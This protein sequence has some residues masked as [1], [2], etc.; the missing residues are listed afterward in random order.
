MH[1]SFVAPRLAS[2]HNRTVSAPKV[3]SLRE[4]PFTAP[5][6]RPASTIAHLSSDTKRH[7]PAHICTC[8]VAA[9]HICTCAVA[10]VRA[11]RDA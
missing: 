1:A 2:L 8:A 7:R 5:T 4:T 6:Q 3:C 11:F 10:A 9:A